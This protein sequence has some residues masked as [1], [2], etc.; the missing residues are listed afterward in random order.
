MD[1]LTAVTTITHDHNSNIMTIPPIQLEQTKTVVNMTLW[2]VGLVARTD[3]CC[4]ERCF[5]LVSTCGR[6]LASSFAADITLD[7]D[8]LL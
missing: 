5:S 3:G 1:F 2:A 6:G 4:L 8:M 7:T